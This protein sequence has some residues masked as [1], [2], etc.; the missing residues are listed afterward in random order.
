MPKPSKAGL[1]KPYVTQIHNSLQRR[2][3]SRNHHINSSQGLHQA[4]S[5]ISGPVAAAKT[6]FRITSHKLDLLIQHP[7]QAGAIPPLPASH[8]NRTQA[9]RPPTTK[10]SKNIAL[11]IM[12]NKS[13]AVAQKP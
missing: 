12:K 7:D 10:S 6:Q 9:A 11:Q 4:G 2:P 8:Y 5:R 1:A 13:A 3:L